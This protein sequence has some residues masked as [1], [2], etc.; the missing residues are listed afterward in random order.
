M[1]FWVFCTAAVLLIPAVMLGIGRRFQNRPPQKINH[2]YG[3]RTTRS[4]KNQQTWEFAHRCCGRLWFRLGMVLLPLS[5]CAMLLVLGRDI[6]QVS[7][8]CGVIALVQMLVFLGS[9]VPVER[10]LKR[11]FD[12][13]GRKR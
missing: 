13:L 1:G 4:M 2:L 10:A 6:T 11:N 9:L 12:D 5:L 8:W 3:Y 7:I